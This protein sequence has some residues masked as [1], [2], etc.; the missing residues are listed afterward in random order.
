MSAAETEKSTAFILLPYGFDAVSYRA[1]YERAAVPDESPY[2]FHHAAELG[3]KLIF[4]TDRPEGRIG[5]FLRRVVRRMLG[6][7]LMHVWSNR[8][9]LRG[10]DI[11]WTMTENEW[12]A[13]RFLEL[14][15]PSAR[16]PIVGNSV[17]LFNEWEAKGTV[18]RRL[19]RRLSRGAGVLTVH[20]DRYL[21]IARSVL[22]STVRIER[23]FFGVTLDEQD[24]LTP[25]LR[26]RA[27]GEPVRILAMGSD[28]TRDWDTFL[29]AFGNDPRFEIDLVCSWVRQD[30]RRAYS[31]LL[32][33]EP[34]AALSRAEMRLLYAWSDIVVVPMVENRFSGITSAIDACGR[35][36]PVICSHTGGVPTYFD[37]GEVVYVAPGDAE[38]M[39]D[40][41]LLPNSQLL[42]VARAGQARFE[43]EDYSTRGMV[44]RYATLSRDLL[45]G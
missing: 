16:R 33:R 1:A 17:W 34:A 14:L 8:K 36:K 2:G 5:A 7:D 11:V 18:R 40:A 44:A 27:P 9:R 29:A 4:S 43:R 19:M 26:A 32:P 42:E 31:N 24:R 45:K 41:A 21:P 30:R 13:F 37:A 3:W 35:G 12:L 10:A 22:P 39:R 6:F 23:M 15:H 38:A 28:W 25:A 20:S